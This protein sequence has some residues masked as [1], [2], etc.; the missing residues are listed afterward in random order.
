MLNVIKRFNL[1]QIKYDG[2][3]TF[4][5]NSLV[6]NFI[7]LERELCVYTDA[8]DALGLTENVIG[9]SSVATRVLSVLKSEIT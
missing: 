5:G 9:N 6:D 7:P 1:W 3:L 8:T 2:I 4:D